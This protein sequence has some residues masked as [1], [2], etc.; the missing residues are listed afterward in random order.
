[1]SQEHEQKAMDAAELQVALESVA[2]EVRSM[3][4]VL[5]RDYVNGEIRAFTFTAARTRQVDDAGSNAL[6]YGV[7]NDNDVAVTIATSAASIVVPP[8][9]W[10]VVPITVNGSIE[11]EVN[12]EDLGT[13]EASVVRWRFPTPQPCFGVKLT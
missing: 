5:A 4:A 2:G 8:R 10:M 7:L 9:F 12:P 13:E 3:T 1:M 6:A 11:L